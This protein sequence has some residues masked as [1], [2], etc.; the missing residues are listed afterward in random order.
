MLASGMP[1]D[2]CLFGWFLW[3]GD[4]TLGRKARVWGG[5]R[6]PE[7]GFVFKVA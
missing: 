6:P 4:L 1:L 3:G 7:S 5:K 2:V